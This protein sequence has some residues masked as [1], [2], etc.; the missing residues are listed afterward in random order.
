VQICVYPQVIERKSLVGSFKAPIQADGSGFF[1]PLDQILGKRA[2]PR[3]Y[4]QLATLVAYLA[5]EKPQ[6]LPTIAKEL[7]DG[8]T[9]EQ[10]FNKCGTTLADLQA[11]WLKWGREKIAADDDGAPVLPVPEEFRAEFHPAAGN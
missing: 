10:A 8:R 4:A 3:T 9:S 7:V 1:K 11:A 6:W 5:E 2:N